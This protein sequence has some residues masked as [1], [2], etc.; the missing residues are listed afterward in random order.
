MDIG[1]RERLRQVFDQA[2]GFTR[3]GAI[4][5]CLA[6][7]AFCDLVGKKD[8]VGKTVVEALPEL[9]G[10]AFPDLLN[11]AAASG[12]PLVGHGVDMRVVREGQP[13]EEIFVDILFQPLPAGDGGPA[14]IFVQGHEVTGDKRNEALRAAHNKV[15]ELAIGDSPLEQTL[16]ELIGRK[17]RHRPGTPV[18]PPARPGRETPGAMGAEPARDL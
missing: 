17:N 2:P 3:S 16:S 6:N 4:P 15:L 1:E 10:Q 12:E 7:R 9:A 13:I 11:Q 14:I 18:D 8:L 5:V